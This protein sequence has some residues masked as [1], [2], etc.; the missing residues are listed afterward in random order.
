MGNERSETLTVNVETEGIEEATA[1]LEGLASVY[2]GFPAQ[3]T[4]K[5]CSRCTINIY[6]TQ[7]RQDHGG[8]EEAKE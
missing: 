8:D 6:P 5:N 2:D 7:I 1:E 4:V 3:V